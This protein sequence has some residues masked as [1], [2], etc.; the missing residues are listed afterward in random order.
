[1]SFAQFEHL[2]KNYGRE[3]TPFQEQEFLTN[4]QL[5]EKRSKQ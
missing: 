3:K 4:M 5:L 1:M 2:S